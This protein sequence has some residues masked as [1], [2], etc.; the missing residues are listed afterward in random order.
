MIVRLKPQKVSLKES[1]SFN[2]GLYQKS[3]LAFIFLKTYRKKL[4]RSFSHVNNIMGVISRFRPLWPGFILGGGNWRRFFKCSHPPLLSFFQKYPTPHRPHSRIFCARPPPLS[5]FSFIKW[6]F[7]MKKPIFR[8][9][10]PIF[11]PKILGALHSEKYKR[12]PPLEI[13][14]TQPPGFSPKAISDLTKI[15]FSV[16]KHGKLLTPIWKYWPLMLFYAY[17]PISLPFCYVHFLQFLRIS[18]YFHGNFNA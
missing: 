12:V 1:H 2:Y 18:A 15:I 4:G 5:K 7:D 11:F 16:K 10:K 3:L 13:L 17:F 14:V 9:F 8:H 6:N